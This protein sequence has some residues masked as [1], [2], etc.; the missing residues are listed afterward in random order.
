LLL[1]LVAAD[2]N[3][4]AE[5][6]TVN[7]P[8]EE[9]GSEGGVA[10]ISELAGGAMSELSS[11]W[12]AS[13]L[14]GAAVQA[15]LKAA[16]RH[17]YAPEFVLVSWLALG[18]KV[19][20]SEAGSTK[21]FVTEEALGI[22]PGSGGLLLGREEKV[23]GQEEGLVSV[24]S[25]FPDPGFVSPGDRANLPEGEYGLELARIDPGPAT[26][27]WTG[28]GPGTVALLLLVRAVIAEA[29]ALHV[30]TDPWPGVEFADLDLASQGVDAVSRS[31]LSQGAA[32]RSDYLIAFRWRPLSGRVLLV[33]QDA[34]FQGD[35]V[36]GKGIVGKQA[37]LG[38]V[39]QG[40]AVVLVLDRS[41]ELVPFL[42][43]GLDLILDGLAFVWSFLEFGGA[44]LDPLAAAPQVLDLGQSARE[45]ILDSPGE[46][47]CLHLLADPGLVLGAKVRLKCC[48]EGR[49]NL[50]TAF[51]V[52]LEGCPGIAAFLES[53]EQVSEFSGQPGLGLGVRGPAIK[54]KGQVVAEEDLRRVQE[55]AWGLHLAGKHGLGFVEKM[56]VVGA[57]AGHGHDQ[58][59]AGAASCAAN[60][61][62]EIGDPG[63]NGGED[64]GREVTDVDAHLQGGGTGQNIGSVWIFTLY[65]TKLQVFSTASIEQ[66]GMF[67]C[68]DSTTR[69]GLIEAP[70][71][72][73]IGGLLDLV[74][75]LSSIAKAGG[76]FQPPGL[77]G[78]GHALVTVLVRD[79]KAG[80]QGEQQ[81]PEVEGVDPEAAAILQ[82]SDQACDRSVV[83]GG[84]VDV[85]NLEAVEHGGEA[86]AG[87]VH[88]PASLLPGGDHQVEKAGLGIGQGH[89]EA[90]TVGKPWEEGLLCFTKQIGVAQVPLVG[91]QPG[92]VDSAPIA[93][94]GEYSPEEAPCGEFIKILEL[95]RKLLSEFLVQGLGAGEQTLWVQDQGGASNLVHPA[96]SRPHLDRK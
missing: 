94:A 39:F 95:N 96:Y 31:Q 34:G 62:N 86:A 20:G 80:V 81:S 88:E 11:S 27:L 3:Q 82:A 12:T 43:E 76:S 46:F 8:G 93:T 87:P 7:L 91:V 67:F 49:Q 29:P 4:N 64:G 37:F 73:R 47:S 74:A 89:G 2:R 19:Q 61:L 45:A 16:F 23:V 15:G 85:L 48:K 30:L 26:A 38:H 40:V 66:A 1:G 84:L 53:P 71:I 69:G 44:S 52:I 36:F 79:Q 55:A 77:L 14:D 50:F 60:P 5:C 90:G 28:L 68:K 65:K 18:S 21:V 72:G 33:R 78:A 41:S 59:V 57:G 13:W 24:L 22:E 32:G 25:A 58:G 92:M 42:G 63:G 10:F 6:L 54:D 83:Q 51:L 17:T 56:Q 35:A 70:V 9:Q 75:S